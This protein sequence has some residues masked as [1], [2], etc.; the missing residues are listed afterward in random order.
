MMRPKSLPSRV[1]SRIKLWLYWAPFYL[2]LITLALLTVASRYA[3]IRPYDGLECSLIIYEVE[4]VDGPAAKAGIRIGDAILEL[5]GIPIQKVHPLYENKQAGD[6]V[7]LAVLREGKIQKLELTLEQPPARILVLRL[8]PVIVGFGFWFFSTILFALKPAS[9]EVRLFFLFSQLGV[10]VL[11]AGEVSTF[12]VDWA[13]RLFNLSFCL[14]SPLTI[15]LHLVFP[16]LKAF[17]RRR[18]ILGLLYGLGLA[19]SL[20]FVLLDPLLG[21]SPWHPLLYSFIRLYFALSILVAVVS[22]VHT[23]ITA[24]LERRRIRLVALGTAFAFFP[25]I[26][27]SI[28]PEILLDTFV[29]PYELS[30][31]FLILIPLSYAYAIS[32][33]KLVQIDLILNHGVVYFV[34]GVIWAGLYMASV[35]VLDYL[36]PS[37]VIGRPLLGALVTFIMAALF[38][39]LKER[40]QALVDRAFYGGWYDYRSVIGQVSRSLSQ[41]LDT[42]QLVGLLV[43]RLSAT[44]HLKGT[45]LLL[46]N[47]DNTLTVRGNK[48]FL[49]EITSTRLRSDGAL[50][51]ALQKMVEPAE[52]LQLRRAL[53]GSELSAEERDLLDCDEVQLW[54]PLVFKGH[55]RGLILLGAKSTEDFFDAEDRRILGTLAQ[56]AGLA[57]ENVL[58]MEELCRKLDE[59][60]AVKTELEE[61][62][63]RLTMGREEERK[64]LARE[65]HDI[66]VQK[67]IETIYIVKK[68]QRGA[69][70][71]LLEELK[72]LQEEMLYLLKELRRICQELRPPTLDVFGLASA[73]RSHTEDFTTQVPLTVE[74]DLMDDQKQLPDEVAINL[75]RVYQEA[76]T[77]VEKHA[78][79]ERVEVALVLSPD[80][81]M[82][83]IRD[84]GCGFVVPRRL[85]QFVRQGCFGLMGMKERTEMV[86]GRLQV[87]SRPEEGTEIRAQAPLIRM[88]DDG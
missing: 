72:K 28:L 34:I 48:G 71:S 10:M 45:A 16:R 30:F 74:L 19:L 23:Y 18:I 58:L 39:P 13:S 29:L 44:M 59:I 25:L 24:P 80:E 15:H 9:G 88:Q 75:F 53:A 20:P 11:A 73:I 67:L 27:F 81:V 31:P 35:M 64:R 38:A 36:L 65:I 68:C 82:L 76:L 78:G 12:L 1:Q 8:Q 61:A 85:G 4:K 57:A 14:L 5:D 50:V 40:I 37:A 60:T 21:A 43:N 17:P 22:L 86:G 63:Q 87:I 66:P 69:K 26:L 51:R 55:L 77:N 56:Q 3:W 54:L 49:P 46:P 83:S 42:S 47:A 33:Y 70:G 6:R 41:S 62:H 2:A 84:D 32:R 7:L 52:R 79:A